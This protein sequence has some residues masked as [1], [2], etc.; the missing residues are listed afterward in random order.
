MLLGVKARDINRYGAVSR[1]VVSA[2]SAGLL[3]RTGVDMGL[4][5]TGIAGPAPDRGSGEKPVG[6]VW[7]SAR[8][9]SGDE[10][11]REFHFS[12]NSDGIRRQTAVSSLLMTESLALK[13]N[14][15]S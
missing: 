3:E 7:I 2:M 15:P 12:G 14:W 5:V 13:R 8:N 9:I 4:A 11:C 10:L 6:T 1:E